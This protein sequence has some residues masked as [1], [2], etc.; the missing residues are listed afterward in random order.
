MKGDI[1]DHKYSILLDKKTIVSVRKKRLALTGI[2]VFDI[3]T[4]QMRFQHWQR[5]WPW[6]MLLHTEVGQLPERGGIE[7]VFHS[8][9]DLKI[10]WT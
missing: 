4:R 3:E 1:S 8:I 9:R 5:C 2:Y 10:I 6:I 7:W